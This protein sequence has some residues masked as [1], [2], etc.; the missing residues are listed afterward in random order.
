V[1]LRPSVLAAAL[2]LAACGAPTP[3]APTAAPAPTPAPTPVPAPTPSTPRVACGVGAG[4]G[5]GLEEHCPRTSPS[6]LS[7]VDAAINRVVDRHPEL[8][9]R[10]RR[11]GAGGFWV[12]DI[13]GFFEEVVKEIADGSQLC[14]VVDADLEIAV[15]KSNAFSEQYKLMWSSGYLRRGDSSYR[16]TCSP[17]WF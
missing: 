3:A 16:A 17:A 6:Y 7:E 14:A 9:D 8:V 1:P 2:V 10:D 13:D 11:A 4:T 12:Q 5:D 15:K